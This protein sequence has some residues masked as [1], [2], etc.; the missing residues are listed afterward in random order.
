MR[1]LLACIFIELVGLAMMI[2]LI[3]FMA[4]RFGAGPQEVT[5]LSATFSL[6]LLIAAPLWG[7]ASDLWGRKPVLVVSF[8]GTLV[9]FL[10]LAFADS[11]WMLFLAR[12]MAGLLSGEM[13]AGP[14]YIADVT[15]PENRAKSMGLLGAAFGLSF[16]IG[17]GLGAALAGADQA[18]ADFRTPA[19]I[20]TGLAGVALLLAVLFLRESRKPEGRGAAESSAAPQGLRRIL[21]DLHFPNLPLVALVLFLIGCVFSSMEST[22]AIWTNAALDWGP[23][24]VGYLLVFAGVVAVV[25][26]G[27]LIGPLNRRFGET[28]LVIAAAVLL[29]IGMALLPLSTGLPL[30]LLAI[31]CLAAGFGLGNPALQ[32][33]ISQLSGR[34]RTGGALGVGQ[35]TT[36]AARVVG[37][38][39]AGFLFETQGRGAP[40][41]AGALV[42]VVVV[43][44]AMA[45][46]RRVG[47]RPAVQPAV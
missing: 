15:K 30:L 2:P 37:P 29:G 23:R 46:R 42:M 1:L 3:P 38:P 22:L 11:L 16:V 40:Y 35:A 43:L 17:P 45:L 7:R 33:L 27:G 6:A 32:S 19:L 39:I 31:A 41:F 18:T 21:A 34:D 47:D 14:A 5:L 28:R 20:A 26:Q 9:S 25:V 12:T 24:Q 13:A 44:L 10:L 36:S 8:A 4:L